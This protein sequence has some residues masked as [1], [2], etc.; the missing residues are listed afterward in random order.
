MHFVALRI[1]RKTGWSCAGDYAQ[2]KAVLHEYYGKLLMKMWNQIAKF[3]C[4]I[5]MFV[6]FK[7]KQ[8]CLF[9]G[10]ILMYN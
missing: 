5:V 8:T 2:N 1:P 3:R 7:L 6:F 4:K 9:C 10:D